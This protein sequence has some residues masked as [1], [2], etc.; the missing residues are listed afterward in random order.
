MLLMMLFRWVEQTPISGDDFS[1][2]EE[3]DQAG[4]A[5]SLL[6]SLSVEELGAISDSWRTEMNQGLKL[7]RDR[8]TAIDQLPV[9]GHND[10]CE[11]S[12][13]CATEPGSDGGSDVHIADIVHWS[14]LPSRMGRPCRMDVRF[15]QV[16]WPTAA[17]IKPRSY[18]GATVVHPALG[19]ILRRSK[20]DTYLLSARM[21][22]LL[23]M[24]KV[25]AGDR[26]SL[27]PTC[28]ACKRDDTRDPIE[29]CALCLCHWHA[30]CCAAL[31][32]GPAAAAFGVDRD[33]DG[34]ALD[35][36]GPS[37]MPALFTGNLCSLCSS[38]VF[39]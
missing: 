17:I 15:G 22:R 9:G 28:H 11:L 7:L 38:R 21:R 23:D 27:A 39:D 30:S 2:D 1:C 33:G 14:Y 5:P 3:C 24:F 19:G 35:A 34:H 4:S 18:A 20:E 10:L 36:S 29:R 8:L 25:A 6:E 16:M 13:M 32:R 12:M 37:P 26:H 31:C